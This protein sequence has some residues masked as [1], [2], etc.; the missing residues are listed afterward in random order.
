MAA[1][2]EG[3]ADDDGTVAVELVLQS[4]PAAS[5]DKIRGGVEI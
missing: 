5:A 2:V 1:T 3:E 4:V